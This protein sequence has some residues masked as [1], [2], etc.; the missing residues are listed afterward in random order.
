MIEQHFSRRSLTKW[1][2]LPVRRLLLPAFAVLLLL[3]PSV[4]GSSPGP[5]GQPR[6]IPEIFKQAPCPTPHRLEF[7]GVPGCP[8]VSHNDDCYATCEL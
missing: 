3:G 2:D 8:V 4:L 1:L 7:V 5:D 6:E